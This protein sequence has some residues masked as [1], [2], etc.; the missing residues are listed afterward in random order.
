MGHLQAA[1]FQRQPSESMNTQVWA[2]PDVAKHATLVRDKDVSLLSRYLEPSSR[3]KSYPWLV[4]PWHT[5]MCFLG[6]G[7]D[8]GMGSGQHTRR[9]G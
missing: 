6:T 9:E 7:Y 4:S 8:E 3:K 2:T 5:D 1:E